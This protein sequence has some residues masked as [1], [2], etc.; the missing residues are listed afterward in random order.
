MKH[1]LIFSFLFAAAIGMVLGSCAKDDDFSDGGSNSNNSTEG[2]ASDG[3]APSFDSSIEEYDGETAS[4]AAND[5]VGSDE[6]IYWEANSFVDTVTVIYSGTSATVTT[7]NSAINT[8]V[9]GAYVAIDMQTN[10]VKNVVII[11]SGK[12]SDGQLKIYGEKKFL[13]TLNGLDLTSTIGPAINNQCHK[14]TFVYLPSGTT[15]RLTDASSY[16]TEP[17][18]LDSSVDEDRKGCFFSEGNLIFSGAGVLVV[19]GN[20][21]HGIATD[22]Y[23][24]TRPGTTIAVTSAAKNAIHVKGD[25]DD[26]IGIKIAGGLIYANTSATAGKGLKTDLNVDISGGTLLLNTSG[27]SEYDSDEQDTSSPSCIKAD[28]NISISGGTLT[29]KSTGT[30]GKGIKADGT[31]DI[32]GGSTTITTTGGKYVYNEA[33]D[34]TASP[35]GVRADGDI[36]IS[37]GNLNIAVTGQSDGSE[38]LESK[39]KISVTGGVNYIYAY[40]DAMNAATDITI[41][42]GRTYCYAVNNDGIDSNGS[43]T[44]SG[45]L[46]IGVGTSAPES[47]IDCDNSNKFY[48]NGGTVIA[49]GGTLQS[50]PSSSSSQRSV[51]V[52]SVTATKDAFVSLLSSSGSPLLTFQYPRTLQGASLFIST[53]D[54]TSGSTYI[55][56]TGGTLT[57]Y[58]DSWNGWYEAGTWSGGT[59]LSSFTSSSVVTTVGNSS[60]GGGGG[61]QPGGGGQ[62]GGGRW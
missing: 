12:S 44:I 41:S 32:S 36:T 52:N 20:Y 47:G 29:L 30:G 14:R 34:L 37:G 45:G 6:D 13:L 22:G 43:L 31:L 16:S 27:G 17:F 28:G 35:K 25:S 42:G 61:N 59:Q 58:T 57:D 53:P 10:S 50:D 5:V 62:P 1:R 4:D 39:S 51:V 21:K 8:N 26:G 7:T 9:S 2:N 40:D 33:Q 54:I 49:M 46:V 11:A 3:D 38:G 15:N 23:F 19:E 18:T 48:I 60:N 55:L 56:S 24:Y